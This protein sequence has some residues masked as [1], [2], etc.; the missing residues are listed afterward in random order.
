MK[1][2]ENLA[3]QIF[4]DNLVNPVDAIMSGDWLMHRHDGSGAW[5]CGHSFEVESIAE[6][7]VYLKI[8]GFPIYFNFASLCFPLDPQARTEKQQAILE[9]LYNAQLSLFVLATPSGFIGCRGVIGQSETYENLLYYRR[10]VSE[11]AEDLKTI[12]LHQNRFEVVIGE[13]P[14][15][16]QLVGMADSL[17][18]WSA[19]FSDSA[20]SK[21]SLLFNRVIDLLDKEEPDPDYQVG[22]LQQLLRIAG[23]VISGDRQDLVLG[24]MMDVL[25]SRLPL[26]EEDIYDYLLDIQDSEE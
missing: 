8:N 15:A 1:T 10:D 6:H 12:A 5:S 20:A 19:I 11:A 13:M 24:A 22:T 4:I 14:E 9:A 18:R 21:V 16:V 23:K 3:Q 26:D 2:I 17:P 25:S 7:G